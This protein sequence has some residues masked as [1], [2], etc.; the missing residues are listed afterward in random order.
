MEFSTLEKKLKEIDPSINCEMIAG[1][2]RSFKFPGHTLKIYM[3]DNKYQGV[4][5]SSFP[6]NC[7][8]ILMDSFLYNLKTPIFDNFEKVSILLR[9]FFNVGGIITVLGEVHIKEESEKYNI[10]KLFEIGFID[11]GSYPN[12]V[13]SDRLQHV[14]LFKIL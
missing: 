4:C 11:V 14:L 1:N 10:E 3:G 13:H 2:P 5:F 12:P 9:H 7:G 8:S 6:N